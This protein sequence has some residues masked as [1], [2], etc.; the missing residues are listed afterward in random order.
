[1]MTE[2][3][4]GQLDKRQLCLRVFV[5][6]WFC[7]WTDDDRLV[8]SWRTLFSLDRWRKVFRDAPHFRASRKAHVTHRCYCP[9]G[10]VFDGGAGAMGFS[11]SWFYSHYTGR[12]PSTCDEV[13]AELESREED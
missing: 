8:F 12:V 5:S 11:V 1:M 6:S 10:W 7:E 3:N 9:D 4:F 2:W 13:I